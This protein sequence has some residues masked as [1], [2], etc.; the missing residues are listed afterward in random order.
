MFRRTLKKFVAV[1]AVMMVVSN[2]CPAFSLLGPYESWMD[3]SRGFQN[4]G[5]IGGPMELRAGYRW[6][7][8]VITY[9]FDQSFIDYFGTNGVAEVEKAIGILNA[10]PPASLINFGDYPTR[11]KGLDFQAQTQGLIDLKST[12]LSLLLEQMGLTSPYTGFAL[13]NF[14]Y[15]GTNA[16]ASSVLV[17]NYDPL[18]LY[19]TNGIN[20]VGYTYYIA[21]A[22]P[23]PLQFQV[24]LVQIDP[25]VAS[26]SAVAGSSL[27]P[28]SS[29]SP[30]EFYRGITPDDVGGL[31]FLLSAKNTNVESLLP[32]V[33]G[34]GAN[35][36]NF[37]NT[38]VRP[39]V[40]KVTLTPHTVS[41]VDGSFLTMTNQF[42]D[43]YIVGGATNQQTMERV[44]ARPDI[45]FTMANIDLFDRTGPTNWADNAA[46]NANPTGAGPGVIQPGAVIRFSRMGT[47]FQSDRF[48]SEVTVNYDF[49][50]WGSFDG[51]VNPI[52]RYPVEN[53]APGTTEVRIQFLDNAAAGTFSIGGTRWTLPPQSTQ[54]FVLHTSTDLINW[55]VITNFPNNGLFHSCFYDSNNEVSRFF[56]LIPAP[57]Q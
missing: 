24:A 38:A 42:I 46:L 5:D 53:S 20:N 50:H 7:V 39:G 10:V 6:N 56:R 34:V 33:Y 32:N 1:I 47:F 23:Y 30:G 36:G 11:S 52:V 21:L 17:R 15:D 48:S 43:T 19:P 57:N 22:S 8:P 13:R 54:D 3:K 4:P 28:G 25:L 12:S 45:L 18:T 29:L 2:Q 9:G 31:Y 55:T 44:I 27:F 51:S 16:P 41:A 40:G 14:V 37:V 49:N 26:G 35:S